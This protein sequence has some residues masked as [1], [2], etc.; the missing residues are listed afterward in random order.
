MDSEEELFDSSADLFDDDE[1][2]PLYEEADCDSSTTDSQPVFPIDSATRAATHDIKPPIQF[3]SNILL[4]SKDSSQANNSSTNSALAQPEG[5]SLLDSYQ[6]G[7]SKECLYSSPNIEIDEVSEEESFLRPPDKSESNDEVEDDRDFVMGGNSDNSGILNVSGN[8]L[9]NLNDDLPEQTAE[10]SK[11]MDTSAQRQKFQTE[12]SRPSPTMPVNSDASLANNL[13]NNTD[14]GVHIASTSAD[15]GLINFNQLP[16]DKNGNGTD[17]PGNSS[18][19]PNIEA[20]NIAQKSSSSSLPN[21]SELICPFC[22]IQLDALWLMNNHIETLHSD[23]YNGEAGAFNPTVQFVCPFCDLDL[24]NHT[25]LELHLLAAHE[26]D[27]EEQTGVTCP[28]CAFTCVSE[29]DLKLHIKTH[30]NDGTVY[31]IS[32]THQ[33]IVFSAPSSSPVLACPVCS[34]EMTDAL[35]LTSHVE[36]HFNPRHRPDMD[37]FPSSDTVSSNEQVVN[38]GN[39]NIPA[40]E[41]PLKEILKQR[42]QET[43]EK[44]ASS[45]DVPSTNQSVPSTSQG[46]WEPLDERENVSYKQQFEQNLEKAVV[47][48]KMTITDYHAQKALMAETELLGVDNGTTRTQGL[49]EKMDY[50]YRNHAWAGQVAYLCSPVDHF[51]ASFGDRGWGCGYRNFQMMLSCL[52]RNPDYARRIFTGDNISIPSIPKIQQMI[53]H[54]WNKGFDPPGCRQLGGHLINTSKWIGATE[55]VA[56]LSCLGIKCQLVDFPAPSAPD[57][58]HPLLMEWVSNYFCRPQQGFLPPLYL[59]HQGHSRTIIGVDKD[60]GAT[61]ILLFDPGTPSSEMASVARD[62]LVFKHM[63]IFRRTQNGFRSRQYQIVSIIGLLT[64]AEYEE[65]KTLKSEQ[66]C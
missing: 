43:R 11:H 21:V 33:E 4:D 27:Q 6:E 8:Y 44:E 30:A 1:E 12:S 59:Q 56:T 57:G 40:E 26:E 2:E 23:T 51:S 66:V 61:K 35:L 13:C 50:L 29:D 19:Q 41:K 18:T 10:G 49:I 5:S 3:K 7:S 39:G 62:K 47:S 60:R 15:N 53:E 63:R 22:N 16:H 36:S 54:A 14:P 58:T 34:L 52:S 20:E 25:D 17:H 32:E 42:W 48:G 9:H 28:L 46:S 24:G 55:I 64:D 38:Q 65:S 37:S 45:Q 31:G